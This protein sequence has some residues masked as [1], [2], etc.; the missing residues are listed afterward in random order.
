MGLAL[1]FGVRSDRLAL[2]GRGLTLL[3]FPGLVSVVALLSLIPLPPEVLRHIAPG[4]SAAFPDR[5]HAAAID[6]SGVIRG[7][8]VAA[9]I[10]G[11]ILGVAAS[12]PRRRR[13]LRPERW[14]AGAA[15][16]V[17]VLFA[18]HALIQPAAMYGFLPVNADMGATSAP[19]VNRN[20]V[21]TLG[22]VLGVPIVGGLLQPVR[23]NGPWRILLGLGLV[24]CIGLVLGTGALGVLLVGSLLF[25]MALATRFIGRWGALIILPLAPLGALLAMLAESWFA[26][27]TTADRRLEQWGRSLP[28]LADFPVLG[29]GLGGYAE[30]FGPYGPPLQIVRYTHM[31]H[32]AYQWLVELGPV[33][34]LLVVV[35]GMVLLFLGG[36]PK[37]LRPNH[38]V[39]LWLGLSALAVALH[40][41]VDFPMQLPAILALVFALLTAW[42]TGFTG[43]SRRPVAWVRVGLVLGVVLQLAAAIGVSW[44]GLIEVQAPLLL[45]GE[46]SAAHIDRVAL[47]AP[48]RA[49]PEL[50]R[51]RSAARQGDL[52]AAAERALNAV[53][54]AP[55]D[56]VV[57]LNAGAVL[58]VA[59]AHEDAA[60]VL[61]R[62][63]VRLPADHRPYALASRV[64]E[65]EGDREEATRQWALALQ[66]WPWKR[67]PEDRPF[68][69]ALSL[70]PIGLWWLEQLAEGPEAYLSANLGYVLLQRGEPLDALIA[71]DQAAVIEPRYRW[72]P[73]RGVALHQ[74]GQTDE[75]LAFLAEADNYDSQGESR[76]RRAVILLERDRLAEARED[77][78]AAL[79]ENPQIPKARL[80]VLRATARIEGPAEALERAAL[81]IGRPADGKLKEA[82]FIAELADGLGR[83]RECLRWLSPWTADHPPASRLADGCRKRCLTCSADPVRGT[84][85]GSSED[86]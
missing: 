66:R 72:V 5:W 35:G 51:A 50:A 82:M 11:V 6:P 21:G 30:G 12:A 17:A 47:I 54:R 77:A 73:R 59:G 22:L 52:A 41:A 55:H 78:Y 15:L 56:P 68:E 86:P 74:I 58:A 37:A 75:A 7:L 43:K 10:A 36:G 29:T 31:H 62:A 61:E 64:A 34:F 57:L 33:P 63:T 9:L 2:T 70:K 18:F 80:V 8:S 48:W 4:T 60:R 39:G 71:L 65:A 16:V 27:E 26:G 24:A 79:R 83:Q 40:S 32:D 45:R 1:A 13:G 53:D 14:A 44:T 85:P 28:M 69:R 81:L 25:I 3:V 38:P 46:P 20:F 23:R 84:M 42:M 49:E 76:M 67:L 19:F